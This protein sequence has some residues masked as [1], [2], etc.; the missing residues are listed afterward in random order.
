MF[1]EEATEEI[2]WLNATETVDLWPVKGAVS[3]PFKHPVYFKY[4]PG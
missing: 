3:I 1:L 2:N 4:I